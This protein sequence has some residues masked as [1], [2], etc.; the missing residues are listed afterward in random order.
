M[1]ARVHCGRRRFTIW[2]GGRLRKPRAAPAQFK[3]HCGG[4]A[5]A[6][7]RTALLST[8]HRSI[9]GARTRLM[10]RRWRF[11]RA[12]F[13]RAAQRTWR[14]CCSRPLSTPTESDAYF[15]C[16]I[17]SCERAR[18]ADIFDC[19]A[20]AFAA[21]LSL[22]ALLGDAS[23]LALWVVP[24][25][26]SQLTNHLLQVG[27]AQCRAPGCDQEVRAQYTS[28]IIDPPAICS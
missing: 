2:R 3:A 22:C 24:Q 6:P 11:R 25:P 10:K 17:L 27:V 18:V 16:C 5:H 9:P 1:P 21:A 7:M 19:V 20:G 26:D 12:G 28:L 4:A 23:S 8:Y 13:Q 15:T 14:R